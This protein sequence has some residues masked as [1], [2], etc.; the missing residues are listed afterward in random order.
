MQPCEEHF[1]S[2][3]QAEAECATADVEHDTCVHASSQELVISA[4]IEK[5]KPRGKWDKRVLLSTIQKVT[6][7]LVLSRHHSSNAWILKFKKRFSMNHVICAYH[8]G[9]DEYYWI[10]E[11]HWFMA[12][13]IQF[14][15]RDEIINQIQRICW[16]CSLITVLLV[17]FLMELK[18]SRIESDRSKDLAH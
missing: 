11:N 7:T 1:L 5:D 2:S 15:G 8:E 10:N 17:G 6:C 18:R 9:L 3:F 13:W 12:E 14:S 16:G 4:W